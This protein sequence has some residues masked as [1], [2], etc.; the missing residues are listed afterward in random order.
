MFRTLSIK[1]SLAWQNATP[2]VME[3]NI[4]KEINS[5]CQVR[6]TKS[7]T[8]FGAICLNVVTMKNVI[9][10]MLMGREESRCVMSG[11]MIFIYL[12]IGH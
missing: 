1:I 6:N 11:G 10:S 4:R 12:R 5:D 2:F 9:V 3:K 7:C 8:V